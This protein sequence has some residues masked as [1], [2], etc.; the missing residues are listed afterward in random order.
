MPLRQLKAFA[1][2]QLAPGEQ[3]RV[4]LTVP[5]RAFAWYDVDAGQWTI[6]PGRYR[7]HIG[8]SSRNVSLVHDIEIGA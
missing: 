6:T 3:A 7:L 4:A 1:K 5:T 2:Q 8:T